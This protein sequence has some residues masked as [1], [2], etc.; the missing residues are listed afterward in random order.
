MATRE[1]V[2]ARTFVELADTLVADFD[3]VE[4]LSLVADR[5]VEVLEAD[6]AGIILASPHG[7]LKVIA[8]SNETMRLLELFELQSEQGPCLDC[9]RSGIPVVNQDLTKATDRW[10]HFAPVALES[11]FR[12]VHALPMRLRGTVIG[13]LNMFNVGAGEML[14]ANLEAAQALADIA[15]IAIL[16]HRAASEAQELNNQLGQALNSRIVIE[17]SKGMIAQQLSIDMDEAFSTLRTHARNHSL[18]LADVA[19][20]VIEGKLSAALLDKPS[21]QRHH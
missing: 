16:Q 8:S 17:Q 14:P 10:P 9:Y 20:D 4:L 11:G 18:R 5:C 6:A 3:V 7:D 21:P 12:S 1:R 15:T 19:S 2:L 13:A